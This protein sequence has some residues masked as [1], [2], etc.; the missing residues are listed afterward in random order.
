MPGAPACGR[1]RARRYQAAALCY[2][3]FVQAEFEEAIA[4]LEQIVSDHGLLLGLS[5]EDRAR[6]QRAASKVAHPGRSARRQ[7]RHRRGACPAPGAWGSWRARATPA[8]PKCAP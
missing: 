8:C 7:R 1:H 6:L 5:H 2:P 4:V 3:S